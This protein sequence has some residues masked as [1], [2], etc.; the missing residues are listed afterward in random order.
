M[1]PSLAWG[2]AW[3]DSWGWSWGPLHQVEEN[4]GQY[5]GSGKNLPVPADWNT[6]RSQTE[7]DQLIRKVLD[8]W[9]FIEQIQLADRENNAHEATETVAIA[10]TVD[11]RVIPDSAAL[12]IA[13]DQAPADPTQQ[14][15]SESI[16]RSEQRKRNARAL[17]LIFAEA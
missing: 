1:E 5:Y 13:A 2:V 16:K 8:K 17:A 14:D 3:G 10:S 7:D 6:Q 15:G 9:E 12:S 11:S 4:P